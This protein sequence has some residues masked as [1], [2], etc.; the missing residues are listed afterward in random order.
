MPKEALTFLLGHHKREKSSF[1]SSQNYSW[2]TLPFRQ[3][4]TA[5]FNQMQDCH[6]LIE[7]VQLSLRIRIMIVDFKKIQF[8]WCQITACNQVADSYFFLPKCWQEIST[9][10]ELFLRNTLSPSFFNKQWQCSWTPSIQA[11]LHLPQDHQISSSLTSKTYFC[12]SLTIEDLWT[13]IHW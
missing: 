7:L 10:R 1:T 8:S 12:C 6:G 4:Q 2:F 9:Y 13:Q 5:V 3:N 11:D